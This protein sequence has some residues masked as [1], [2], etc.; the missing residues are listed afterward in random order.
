VGDQACDS[1]RW[2]PILGKGDFP[3]DEKPWMSVGSFVKFVKVVET[4]EPLTVECE[5]QYSYQRHLIDFQ[6]RPHG[7]Q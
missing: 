5:K 3:V 6:S 7:I 1:S 4:Y 2:M